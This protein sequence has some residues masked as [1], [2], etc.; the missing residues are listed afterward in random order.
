MRILKLVLPS[1]Q[2]NVV[3]HSLNKYFLYNDHAPGPSENVA[4]NSTKFLPSWN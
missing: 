3:I 1:V 4:V 2:K